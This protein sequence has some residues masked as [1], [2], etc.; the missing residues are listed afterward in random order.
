MYKLLRASTFQFYNRA[1]LKHVSR[2]E[3]ECM[4]RFPRSFSSLTSKDCGTHLGTNQ[5]CRSSRC[6]VSG[7]R[8]YSSQKEARGPASNQPQELYTLVEP[9]K[10]EQFVFPDFD[11]PVDNEED[12]LPDHL[13]SNVLTSN[14][15]TKPVH[16]KPGKDMH[17]KGLEMQLKHLKGSAK[18]EVEDNSLIEF[19]DEGFPLDLHTKSKKVK[20]QQ[21]IY[22]SPD[23]EVA[24][25]DSCCSG[26]GALMH[27][28]DPEIP[29]F[30]PSE[31]FKAL[32]EE[33]KLKKAI[34]QRCYL[35]NHHQKA[36]NVTMSKEEYRAIVKRIKSE[37][38]LVLLIVDLLDLPDSIIPDL[39]ELVGKNK[40]IVILGN[41]IDLLPG[42]AENY[43]QRIKRQLAAYCASMGIST[44]DTKDIHLISA[45]TG[46]GIENLISRLQSTWKYNG[47]VYLVG[48]AN[49]G[50]ST[51]F[52]T[53]LESD[54]C[55]SRASDVMHKATISPWPGTTL[56][57]LKFP[58]IN[59][60]PYRMFRRTER[61]KQESL[62]TEEDM[63]PQE[64]KR[65]KQFSKQGY[66]VGHIGRTFRTN[67]SLK[68]DLVE[69]DP[70][71]LSFGEDVEEGVKQNQSLDSTDAELTYNEIKDAHWFY[72]TPGIMK[73]HDV[74]SLLNHQEVK[75]VVP[76]HAITPRTYLMNPGMVLF[77]GALARI[78]YLE[79]KHSCWLT[80]VASSRI[81]IHITNL[82]K[83]D[84]VY[85]KHA[86]NIL[87]AV[88]SGGEE[89]M[90]TFPPLIAQDFELEGQG[91]N[92]AI[93]DIKISS[94]GWVAVTAAEG[95]QLFLRTHAPEAAGLCLRTPPLLPHI[96]NC[97]GQR[98]NKSPAYKTRKPQ[99]LVDVGLSVKAAER[100]KVRRKK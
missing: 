9:E 55:K 35:I 30:L 95:D 76:T 72:D 77:L 61:L 93:T 10:Q 71:S 75:L 19:H 40:H 23:V 79:G 22:G 58:I 98:I 3:H 28:T 97:K 12:K 51:L 94:A 80:V 44:I 31:K 59:P 37:K 47:D 13:L 62:L 88:P 74:L 84:A 25:S 2:P 4:W 20:K 89:R 34:C 87:L 11:E 63:N 14:V 45:K 42:D 18:S 69:F 68:K 16:E 73:E 52:N 38:A 46:Y 49:A 91:C 21:K 92:T 83:A 70:D 81:P 100:L 64:L 15:E 50:K 5:R 32:V 66:L 41:K 82:D 67:Q 39:P 26:C 17:I 7:L 6:G 65:I 96:V 27:C 56:N 48:T 43:L 99:A 29:G 85:Q 57:L 53:L 54:Y 1:C 8:C 33:D 60:T 86:G 90:K 36:L 78:D 24:V